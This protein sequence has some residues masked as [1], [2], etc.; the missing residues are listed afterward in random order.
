MAAGIVTAVGSFSFP[1][2]LLV[3]SLISRP[4]IA[5][6]NGSNYF[7]NTIKAVELLGGIGKFIA[8]GDKVGLLINSPWTR[9]GTYTNP[10][11]SLAVLKMCIDAGATEFYSIENAFLQIAHFVFPSYYWRRSNLYSKFEDKVAQIHTVDTSK[12]IKI[13][14]GKLLKKAEMATAFIECDVLINIPIVKN[15][16]GTNFTCTLKNIMGACS[17]TTDRFFHEGSGAK[18]SFK[19]V[20]VLSQG[21]ADANLVR[22]PDLCIVD[23]TNFVITN[24][25]AGPG[26]LK[27]A[28]KIVAGVNCV[29][30]DTYC[31]T[32][33]GLKP[34]DVLMI[35]YASEHNLGEKDITKL[36][37][38]E[39]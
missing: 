2:Q 24:G 37:I 31:A 30:V 35:R 25:P 23:A 18:G 9:P 39:I 28:E 4:D 29:S 38:K 1:S 14:S 5:V 34:D 11:I 12:T 17:R 10:D 7:E 27:R 32:L 3:N 21:I 19:D 33:L 16:Q 6:V 36:I 22:K 13:E 26:E 8:K 20:G 15:H